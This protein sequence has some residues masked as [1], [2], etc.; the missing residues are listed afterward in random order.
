M[1]LEPVGTPC[2]TVTG[3][4]HPRLREHVLSYGGFRS[5]APIGHRVL[6][7]NIP[8]LVIDITGAGRV[9]TG[10]LGAAVVSRQ[11]R[12]GY[13]VTVGLSPAGVGRR[14]LETAFQ[15]SIGLTP[16]AVARIARFQRAITM[17]AAGAELR[18]VA[19]DC[20]YADQSH[21]TRDTRARCGVTPTELRDILRSALPPRIPSRPGG[22]RFRTVGA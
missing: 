21:F 19:T 4:P 13:G 12:W 6:P 9:V 2:S 1:P 7:I 16:G 22:H 11:V 8:A 15:R 14:R 20:G 5:D 10:A 3:R 18:R 17:V